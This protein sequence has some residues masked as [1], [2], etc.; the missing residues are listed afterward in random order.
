MDEQRF[1]DLCREQFKLYK[2]FHNEI[3]GPV[4]HG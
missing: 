2:N 1:V 4:G 3:T